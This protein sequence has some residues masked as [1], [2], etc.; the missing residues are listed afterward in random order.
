MAELRD[1][2]S[3]ISHLGLAL[4]Q[5]NFPSF[6]L[7]PLQ[8]KCFEYLL[9]GY[10]IIGVL[11]TGFGKS[12]L[13]QLLPNFL[14]VKEDK[15]VVIVV[16]PLNSIIEDQLK[17]LGER[18]ITAD[19]LQLVSDD[20]EGIESLFNP[21]DNDESADVSKL[22]S[23]SKKLLSGDVQIIFA[24]PESLLSKE[25]R[26]LMKGKVFQRNVAACVVD[27]AHCVEIW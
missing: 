16:C 5:C 15:N 21:E 24:H 14:P 13:F 26:E 7:K 19:V 17:V 2:L 10:D 25:G 12:L 20:R 11:P 8:V 23:P 9:N 1:N 27:E 4:N 18:G 6:C 3:V 22:K